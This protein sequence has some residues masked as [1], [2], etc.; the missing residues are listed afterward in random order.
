VLDRVGAADV[1]HAEERTGDQRYYV[2]DTGRFR[3]ATGWS[4][5]VDVQDGVE[6]LMQWLEPVEAA[7]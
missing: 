1:A 2:A 4:P 7:A 3:A 6:R 5:L